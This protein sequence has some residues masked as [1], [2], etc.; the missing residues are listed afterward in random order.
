MPMDMEQLRVPSKPA[1]SLWA[2]LTTA[3]IAMT[4][5]PKQIQEGLKSAMDW[6]MIAMEMRTMQTQV[7]Q[8]RQPGIWMPMPMDTEM[9]QSP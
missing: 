8:T 5:R 1:V 2:M 7:S 9:M 6:T 3:P 4:L